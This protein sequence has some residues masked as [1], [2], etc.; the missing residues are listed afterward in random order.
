HKRPAMKL[1]AESPAEHLPDNISLSGNGTAHKII[2]SDAIPHTLLPRPVPNNSAVW[3]D[4]VET[5]VKSVVA[6]HFCHAHPFDGNRAYSSQATGFVV[7]ATCG[8]ILT[9]RHVVSAGPFYGYCIF[10]N[11]EECDVRAVY[12]DPVHDFGILQFDPKAVRYM[13]VTELKLRPN[14]ARVGTEIRL[15]G[16]DAGEKL[17]VQPGVISLLD[18]N[19]PQCGDF[20]TNYIQ[21]ATSS[22]GGSSGSPVVNI[23]GHAIALQAAGRTDA[24]TN[25]F[26]PLDR[27]LRALEC[28]RQGKPI[29]RGTLQ[30]VWRLK[31]LDE[32][33]RLGLTPEWED[34]VRKTAPAQNKMLVVYIIVPGGPGDEKLQEG[35]ILLKVNNELLTQFIH[36]SEILDSSVG[37]NPVKLLVQRGGQDLE[38]ECKVGDLHDIVPARFAQV[39]G[40]TFHDISYQ[41]ASQ[42]EIPI[43]GVYLHEPSGSFQ[44]NGSS[45]VIIDMVDHLPTPNLDEFIQVM[46]TIPDR[47]RVV[48]AYRELHDLQTKI[49]SVI[50]VDRHWHPK[51]R[52]AVRNDETG[53][54]DF[55]DIAEAIS[56]H[57][58]IPY[59]ADFISLQNV[60]CGVFETMHSIISVKYTAPFRLDNYPMK[61]KAGFGLVIDAEKGLAV[62]SRAIV[63]HG[64]SDINVTVA[65]SITINAQVVFL[66][67]LQNYAIIRYDPSLVQAPLQSARL[68]SEHLKLGQ[69]T[70]FV[71]LNQYSNIL[72]AKTT[73]TEIK[74]TSIPASVYSPKPRAINLDT[75]QVDTQLSHSCEGGILVSEDGIVQ[76]L[77]MDFDGA[78]YTRCYGLT[79]PFLLPN[80]SNIEDGTAL[81]LRILNIECD[82][83]QIDQA[84]I[85]GVPEDWIQKVM[86]MSSLRHQLFIIRRVGCHPGKHVSDVPTD[87]FLEADIVLSLDSQPITRV[88]E[89]NKMSEEES[90]DA[91]IVRNRQLMHVRVATVAIEHLETDRVV[92]FC[93]AILQKPHTAVRQQISK[94]HSEVYVSDYYDGS[95]ASLYGLSDAI[96]ITSANGIS[97]PTLDEFV[98]VVRKIP[99][100]TYFRLRTVQ[101]DGRP[102]VVTMKK[103]DHYS[104]MQ[105]Y[106]RDSSVLDGWRIVSY[107]N[108]DDEAE[109]SSDAVTDDIYAGSGDMD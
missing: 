85:M 36:L 40:A 76:A 106:V 103:N 73:V 104:P 39:A 1:R 20:N 47:A 109:I 105:E 100:N 44:L 9:N 49:T 102:S 55:S 30:T 89:L 63:P 34:E 16:N 22:S 78:D 69:E 74:P 72:V 12:R 108:I 70:F 64:L 38:V 82:V 80:I 61:T 19:A 37:G 41:V 18:R 67:P 88:S 87:G 93:G 86:Q 33:R 31:P 77:W 90:F 65:D 45:S 81:K 26:L 8:Y 48:I 17:S 13:E 21:A 83:V 53:I 23:H 96:F 28:I 5:V 98:K 2:P 99:D 56:P 54:W 68:S 52:L 107:D 27:P 94:L 15:I 32:C 6:L 3:E 71:A 43:R 84:R 57:V 46:T 11:H 24:A 75:I 29:T 59:R 62:V 60:S 92:F 35:D 14:E 42:H 51:M 66:H 25:F 95:P 58:P 10:N 101:L 91:L 7:D 50:D 4:A 97:T 79:I